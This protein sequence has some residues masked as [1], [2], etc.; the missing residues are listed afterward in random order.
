MV[1]FMLPCSFW[2]LLFMLYQVEI[3]LVMRARMGKTSSGRFSGLR[4]YWGT[5]VRSMPKKFM[6]WLNS[7]MVSSWPAEK[8]PVML[9]SPAS[10]CSMMRLSR[11]TL[12]NWMPRLVRA[13]PAAVSRSLLMWKMR[14]RGS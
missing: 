4:L 1:T 5:R 9:G 6:C 13:V 12:V 3:K 8:M 7:V 11:V 10:T 2:P 14:F